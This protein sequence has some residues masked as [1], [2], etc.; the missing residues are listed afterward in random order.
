MLDVQAI[1]GILGGPVAIVAVTDHLRRFFA[2][3][4]WTVD[5][6]N[7]SPWPLIADMLGIVWAL[8]LWYGDVLQES[9]PGVALTP[10]VVV[11]VG[12]TVFGLGSSAIVD[13]KRA[14]RAPAAPTGTIVTFS[15]GSGP[16]TA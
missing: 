16:P 2:A 11:L 6:A 12:L 13:A 7:G 9:F 1:V 15:G 3:M 5:R 10:P 8:A 14:L 4:P